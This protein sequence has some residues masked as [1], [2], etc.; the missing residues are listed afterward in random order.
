MTIT[1]N[2]KTASLPVAALAATVSLTV[3]PAADAAGPRPN[4]QMPL[5]CGQMWEATTYANHG[6]DPD[7][8]DLGMWDSDDANISQGEAVLASADGTVTSFGIN[9]KNENFVFLDHGNGW[10]TQHKHLESIPP[11]VVGQHVAQ[12]EQIGRVGN[13]GTQPVEFHLHYTQLSDGEAVGI[14]FNGTAIKTNQ[15]NTDEWG[16]WPSRTGEQLTSSN[17]PGRAFLPFDQDGKHHLFAYT[18]GNGAS[19]VVSVNGDGGGVTKTWGTTANRRWTHFMPFSLDGDQRSISYKAATG[20]VNF[21]RIGAGG[22]TKLSGGTWGKGWTHLM[23]FTLTGKP[24]FVAY[25]SLTG[26]RA[27]DRINAAGTGSTSLAATGWTK[28]WTQLVPFRLGAVQYMLAYRG[29]TGEVK[30]NKISGSGNDV[31]FTTVFQGT[32]STGWTNIVPMVHNGAVHL[33][34]YSQ[35]QGWASFDK[36][37]AGGEGVTHLA[38]TN[39]SRTWTSFSPFTLNGTGHVLAYK[40]GSG[41]TKILKLT[42]DGS[43]VTTTADMNWT[44]GLA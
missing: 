29:G 25:S 6:P 9:S 16:K 34:R 14:A 24:Y 19:A 4:F 33:M 37:N 38:Y 5:A 35:S 26:A 32:W 28:G 27:V 17:C 40:A 10:T 8:I 2:L 7:S 36:V 41:E 30:I 42:A 44:L 15:A 11:L 12:G 20:E 1:A 22:P 39:W 43:A 18:P 21:D 3:C 13:T 31:T 23:P